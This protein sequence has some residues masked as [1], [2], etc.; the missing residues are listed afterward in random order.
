MSRVFIPT[1][2]VKI[3]TDGVYHPEG[4]WYKASIGT[5]L[6]GTRVFKVQL[7]VNGK[8]RPRLTLSY[9]YESK[10]FK[11]IIQAFDFLSNYYQKKLTKLDSA[12]KA[13]VTDVDLSEEFKKERSERYV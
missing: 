4:S 9:D 3:P 13:Q 1:I 12:L 8:I 6:K 7:V 11:K 2:F 10:Q 5:E